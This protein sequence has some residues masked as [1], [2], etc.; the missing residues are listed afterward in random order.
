MRLVDCNFASSICSILRIQNL[1]ATCTQLLMWERN[2]DV[3]VKKWIHKNWEVSGFC[4][5]ENRAAPPWQL[6]NW[7]KESKKIITFF[8]E[9]GVSTARVTEVHRFIYTNRNTE[10]Q[11]LILSK[12]KEII[13]FQPSNEKVVILLSLKRWWGFFN[14]VFVTFKQNSKRMKKWFFSL[15]K[16]GILALFS[17]ISRSQRLKAWT[18]IMWIFF[19]CVGKFSDYILKS[20][21]KIVIFSPY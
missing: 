3:T 15:R 20:R 13:S 6:I 5:R 7:T 4:Y 19:S 17:F 12:S 2:T 18:K 1:T 21:D 8:R 16:S 14:G 10:K 9:S 11:K